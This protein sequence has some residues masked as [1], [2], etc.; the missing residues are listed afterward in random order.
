MKA[1]ARYQNAPLLNSFFDDEW[2]QG[3]FQTP[4]YMPAVN[5]KNEEQNI[6]VELSVPGW[7]KEDFK[8]EVVENELVISAHTED[9]KEELT[10]NYA[11]REFS[12]RS[13]EKRFQLNT[14]EVD[15]E[16]I[17]AKYN[18]GILTIDLPKV[19]KEETKKLVQ[20]N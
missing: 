13:F 20:V 16:N 15:I 10:E 3:M 1:L 17:D 18:A 9:N 4:S 6:F 12:K 19:H 2:I 11:R 14:N 5:I 7:N 8:I